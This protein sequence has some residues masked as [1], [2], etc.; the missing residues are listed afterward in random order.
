MNINYENTGLF[1]INQYQLIADHIADAIII[2]DINF[3]I[4]GWNNAAANIFP[5]TDTE[6]TIGKNLFELLYTQYSSYQIDQFTKLAIT[7]GSHNEQSYFVNSKAERIHQQLTIVYAEDGFIII[8]RPLKNN[9]LTETPTTQPVSTND[10]WRSVVDNSKTGFFLLDRNYTI[11]LVNEY[12]KKMLC[13]SEN[14]EQDF[15]GTN[16]LDILPEERK[17]PA[18]DY[19]NRSLNGERIEYEVDYSALNGKDLWL[20]VSYSPVK[21]IDGSI[22]S[23]CITVN[24]ITKHKLNEAALIKSEQRWK[25]ALDGAGDG[26]WEFNLQTNEVYYSAL[27]KKLLGFTE[28]EFKDAAYEWKSRVH[29]DDVHLIADIDD[30]YKTGV[31]ENHS[32]EYRLSNKAGDFVW[33]LDRGMLLEKDKEGK[34]LILIGTQRNITERKIA[35]E[36]FIKSQQRVFSFMENTPTMC[37]IIDENDVFRYLN[38]PYIDAFKLSKNDI[39]KSVYD[40]FPKN[41][42]DSF[43]E[44]NWKVWDSG[45]AIEAIDF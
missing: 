27:Y 15:E 11:L 16:F 2:T 42:C 20:L 7:N 14:T 9:A 40:I 43:I 17:T 13:H 38:A 32:V 35:D 25:F 36:K 12:G 1:T 39:G 30:L 22:Q 6:K 29:P 44:N 3:D 19:I 41:I 10:N 18:R 28:K 4:R 34:P 33:V 31:I 23:V 21:S 37:W 45:K 5:F 24:N 26:V 8:S